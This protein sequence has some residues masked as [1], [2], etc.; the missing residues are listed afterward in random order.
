MHFPKRG[1]EESPARK[2]RA[3][4]GPSG[5]KNPKRES[6][7]ERRRVE[8]DESRKRVATWPE[9]SAGEL[10]PRKDREIV[11][12]LLRAPGR[13]FLCL[14]FLLLGLRRRGSRYRQD[15][16]L[17]QLCQIHVGDQV[18]VLEDTVPFLIHASDF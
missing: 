11:S 15:K 1:P 7:S 14:F 4:R 6:G 18:C 2:R 5:R 9:R 3:L 16:D 17:L 12:F 10:P 13:G 8:C